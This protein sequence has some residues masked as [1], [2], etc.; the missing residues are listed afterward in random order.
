MDMTQITKCNMETCA[1]NQDAACHTLGINVGPHAE[2]NT[3]THGSSKGGK[4]EVNGAIGA[5][6]ASDCMFN[7]MLEC[8]APSIDVSSH[9]RH[10]DCGTFMPRA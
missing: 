10:A 7:D 3:Y 8:N 2:C 9:E 5:C 6:L 1:Y 4:Q